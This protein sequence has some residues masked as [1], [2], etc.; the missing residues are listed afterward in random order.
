MRLF[1]MKSMHFFGE[2]YSWTNLDLE[3]IRDTLDVLACRYGE[4]RSASVQDT[5]KR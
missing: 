1:L 3:V 4:S 5:H 2:L